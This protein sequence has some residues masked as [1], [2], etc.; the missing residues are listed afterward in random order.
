MVTNTLLPFLRREEDSPA[1]RPDDILAKRQRQVLFGWCVCLS[2]DV[3]QR[4]LI[5]KRTLLLTGWQRSR[6]S[7][8]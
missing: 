8:A 7:S 3:L 6:T 1:P 4:V 2:L 5:N